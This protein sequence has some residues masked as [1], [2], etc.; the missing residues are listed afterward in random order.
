MPPLAATAAAADKDE[1]GPEFQ[2]SPEELVSILHSVL[3]RA[4]GEGVGR[5]GF[6]SRLHLLGAGSPMTLVLMCVRSNVELLP[7]RSFTKH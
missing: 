1:P 3:P 5:C 6:H 4:N 7:S 2:R